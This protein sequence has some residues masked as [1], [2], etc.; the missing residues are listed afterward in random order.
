MAQPIMIAGFTLLLGSG[1][2]RAAGDVYPEDCYNDTCPQ[3][4]DLEAPLPGG[5]DAD[6]LRVT[7]ED[8]KSLL[9]R[10]AAAEQRG[11]G[12][13]ARDTPPRSN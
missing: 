6:L 13:A 7:E 4:N 11:S 3:R 5:V 1:A 2:T 8:L 9:A 10:L 12:E